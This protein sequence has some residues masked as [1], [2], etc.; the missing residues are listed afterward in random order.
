VNVGEGCNWLRN[1]SSLGFRG[2][3]ALNF[4]LIAA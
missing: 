2:T 4:G 3:R 1:V